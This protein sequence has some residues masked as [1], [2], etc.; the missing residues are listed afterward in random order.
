MHFSAR[1]IFLLFLFP[2]LSQAQE[3]N[4]NLKSQW[5]YNRSGELVPY[6]NQRTASVFFWMDAEKNK[7]NF[8]IVEGK[9]PF[10]VFINSK[11]ILQKRGTAKLS[12]DSL[13]KIYSHQLFVGLYSRHGVATLK[14]HIEDGLAIRA[15]ELLPVRKGNYFLDFTILA[16][17]LLSTCVVLLLRTNPTLTF[18]YLDVR[19]LFS[20]QDRDESTLNLRIASSVNLLIYLF[21]SFFL[22]LMLLISLHFMGEQVSWSKIFI[23]RSSLQGLW[24]WVVLSIII[25]GLLMAKLMWLGI[26][27]ALFGFRDT[28]SLQFFNFVRI[29]LISVC[30][31]ATICIAYFVLGVRQESY[32]YHL[33]TI[34]SIVFALGTAI[35][36]FKLLVRMPFHFFHLFSYL[37]ASEIIPLIILIKV[38]YY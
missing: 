30:L 23:I 16:A 6:N 37:C 34:L 15:K 13:S 32:F 3:P 1:L 35:M 17:L 22:G 25:F 11:L 12:I 4:Q 36:Y 10:S 26:L 38:F 14:A 9:H 21:G 27:S 33:L 5:L 19:K 7:N 18:D 2:W 20:F 31:L 8:F 29:I 24:Q 28:V